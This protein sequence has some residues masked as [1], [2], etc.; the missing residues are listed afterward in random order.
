MLRAPPPTGRKTV[1]QFRFRLLF[2]AL[3]A[4]IAAAPAA[5]EETTQ[6]KLEPAPAQTLQQIEPRLKLERAKPGAEVDCAGFIEG[7]WRWVDENHG[8]GEGAH[9]IGAKMASVKIRERGAATYPWGHGAYSEGAFGWA[10]DRLVGR[11]KVLFSDRKAAGGARFDK[12]QADIQ[13][14]AL[15]KDGRVEIMLRSWGDAL[16]RLED[17]RCYRDG[18]LT[19]VKREGNGVSLVSFALRKE[20]ITPDSHPGALW[21]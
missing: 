12:A 5:G 20:A 11:F 13:D 7:L 17:V 8:A 3:A 16:L 18:F 2:V 21:P 4:A 10:G 1:T 9:R 6:R 15:Y 19:G 14:V